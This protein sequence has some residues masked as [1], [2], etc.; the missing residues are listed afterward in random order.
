MKR[1]TLSAKDRWS[2][3]TTRLAPVV[4]RPDTP[5]NSALTNRLKC[6][7]MYRGMAAMNASTIQAKPVTASAWRRERRAGATR[8][9]RSA[10]PRM[11][12]MPMDRR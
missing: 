11:S 2:R 10:E 1:Q 4:V 7:D 9:R 8:S 6:P 3:S 5:S 12:E